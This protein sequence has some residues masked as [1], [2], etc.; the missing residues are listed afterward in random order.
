MFMRR[1]LRDSLAD[2][3]KPTASRAGDIAHSNG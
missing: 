3:K 1:N 2:A